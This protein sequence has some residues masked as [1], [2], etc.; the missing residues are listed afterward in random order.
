[1]ETS[2]GVVAHLVDIIERKEN[3]RKKERNLHPVT[4]YEWSVAWQRAEQRKQEMIYI[5]PP[6]PVL[7]TRQG[8]SSSFFV[9]TTS[10]AL[11][12][13]CYNKYNLSLPTVCM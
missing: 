13:V 2:Q 5:P 7:P 3:S 1:M 10:L 4:P 11:L 8:F 6:H 12:H 9:T